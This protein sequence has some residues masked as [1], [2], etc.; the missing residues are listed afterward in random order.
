MSA[1]GDGRAGDQVDASHAR[2]L[3]VGDGNT[4]HNHFYGRQVS[5]PHR[6][7]VVPVLADRRQHRPADE[8]LAA[9][10][11][12]GTV[13]VC[14]VLAGL[15][16]VGK[17]QLAANLAEQLWRDRQVDLL[18][19]VTATS[20]SSV[21]TSYAQAAGDV[22][23]VEDSDPDQGAGRLLAWL[24]GTDKRWL[25]VL[26]DLADPADLR[27]L[28]PPATATGRTVVTTRRRDAALLQGRT[29]IA[30]SLFTPDEATA[31]LAGKLDGDTARLDEA[32]R[33]AADL[34]YLPLALA[35][36]ATYILDRNLTCV[37]YRKRLARRR[38]AAL[39]PHLLPDDQ[40]TPVADTWALSVDLADQ[41][42][43]GLAQVLLQIAALLDP[44][45]IPL[46]LFVTR[47]V[48]AYCQ[49]RLGVPVDAD[50]THDAVRALHRLSLASTAR[51]AATS[52]ALRVHALVQ[53]A[54]REATP[55]EHR[56]PLAV[57]AADA[58]LE[59]W[60]HTEHDATHALHLCANTIHLHTTT[61][62]LLWNRDDRVHYVLFQ[63]GNSLGGTGLVTAAADYFH[64]L[65]TAA[66]QHLGPD[67]PDTLAARGNLASW[68][69]E[70]GDAAGA[71]T[72][73]EQLL[74]DCL[75]NLG[76][77]HPDTLATRS[78]LAYWRGEAGEAA[79]AATA[80][81]QLLTDYLR[82][83]GPDDPHTLATR[84]NLAYWRGEAGDAAGAATASEQLLTD[85]LRVLG[86]DHPHTLT[87]RGNLASWRG[88]AGDAAG[89]A[90]ASEQLLTDQLRVLGPDHPHTL[91]TR[92]NLASW[93]GEAGDAAGAATAYEQ[94]LTD[95]LRVLGPDHPHTLT[96]RH[97]L[98]YWRGEAGDAAG[99][100]TSFEQLLTD[101]LRVLGP[102]HP[103]TLAC[104][105]SLAYWRGEAGDA[106]GAATASEQLLT[107][108]LRVLGPDHPHTLTMRRFLA[109]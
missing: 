31:Y 20:R 56:R 78:N 19:W 49:W 67:H 32:D 83:F 97:F 18:V 8:A 57:T 69:G 27:G 40:A 58:L 36:A 102:D 61:G 101:Q 88:E 73:S 25:I 17:T 13:V 92:G 51:D 10:G 95:Q 84:G 38:L 60:P 106:A 30:V 104:R 85:Q 24:A 2:G 91:T 35:Q 74:T 41:A 12:G 81:E 89:A 55:D 15:G 62:T 44:N 21:L 80:Y 14:Q 75:R 3:Q 77:D 34:G 68:R 22:T 90:T 4:Q 103:R 76:P 99:A 87:T 46:D 100:A 82:V 6:V 98:A 42:T 39:S 63:A 43:D 72:A 94:L 52:A 86:P 65:H 105:G 64:N 108:Q 107:D 11:S 79:G 28:W 47:A 9:A 7:G 70:A 45:G 16:G 26:D 66:S 59:L 109:Y 5:W 93:R 37:A 1:D 33:L 71:A 96:M 23:G 48:T 54:T 53:R 50:D 29:L